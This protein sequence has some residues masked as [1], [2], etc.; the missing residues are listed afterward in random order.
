[1]GRKSLVA[2][3]N[4]LVSMCDTEFLILASDDDVIQILLCFGLVLKGLMRLEK[5]FLLK[6]YVCDMKIL[7]RRCVLILERIGY[8]VLATLFFAQMF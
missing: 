1:M 7:F 2:H 5:F 3:W 8:I 4:L 6:S